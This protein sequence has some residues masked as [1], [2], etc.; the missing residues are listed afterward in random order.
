MSPTPTARPSPAI[1]LQKWDADETPG[2]GGTNL[3]TGAAIADADAET[4]TEF[5]NNT[6]LMLPRTK[7]YYR[8]RATVPHGA[9]T[10]QA[11]QLPTNI[12]ATMTG[13]ASATTHGDTPGRPASWASRL[14][15]TATAQLACAHVGG[16]VTIPAARTSPATSFRY[17]PAAAGSTRP[18]W[19]RTILTYTDYEP[20][21]RHEVL[22]SRARDQQP[23]RRSVD[24]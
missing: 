11:G 13:A 8:I 22:L 6:G 17:G 1:E 7:Y 19:V 4:V 23:G 14:E 16:A 12:P 24:R 20:R 5:V 2:W 18:P 9:T 21:C 10:P 3:L 15:F